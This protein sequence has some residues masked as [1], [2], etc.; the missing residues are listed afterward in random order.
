M[1]LT[2]KEASLLS[3]LRSHEQLCIEKYSKYA[4]VANDPALKTIF[5][6]LGRAEQNHL[7][8]IN[9]ILS[10]KEVSMSSESPSATAAKTSPAASPC[11]ADERSDDAYLCRDALSMEKH[12]SSVYDTAVFEFTSPVLRDT[13]AH[14]QKEEQ[15]HG[16]TLYDYMETNGMYS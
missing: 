16:E 7:T 15:N 1:T 11:T 5:S 10:G 12:V 8:T 2:Q 13:L 4:A 6:D 9:E 14:I 3:D